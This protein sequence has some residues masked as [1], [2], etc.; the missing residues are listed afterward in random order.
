MTP[1]QSL[2]PYRPPPPSSSSVTTTSSA[3]TLIP[4]RLFTQQTGMAIVTELLYRLL[5]D[6]IGR[7]INTVHNLASERLD[8]FSSFLQRKAAERK[9]RLEA[10]ARER[11]E[12]EKEGG[13]LSVVQEVG[14]LA[15]NYSCPM[16]KV[17]RGERAERRPVPGPPGWV[18][19]V[20]EG[21]REGRMLERDFWIATHGD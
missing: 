17:V 20:L 19:G 1:S 16:E 8:Q 4:S 7:F 14:G 3:R 2:V 21:V 18:K 10:E 15:W 12:K 9:E 6:L 11:A 5:M 13:Q